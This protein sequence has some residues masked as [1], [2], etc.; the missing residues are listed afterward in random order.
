MTTH[1]VETAT[2]ADEAG[3]LATL[4]LA[5]STDPATRWTWPDPGAF[6]SAFPRFAKAL[7]GAA[8]AHGGAHR[9]GS[10]AASRAMAFICRP[11]R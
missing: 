8:F 7:G 1:T 3:V 4:T 9:I 10:A 2:P 5:F 11:S 6:L